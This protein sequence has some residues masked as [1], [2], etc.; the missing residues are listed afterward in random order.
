MT[1]S[2]DD[3]LT[4]HECVILEINSGVAGLRPSRP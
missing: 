4:K 3:V 1:L 2:G